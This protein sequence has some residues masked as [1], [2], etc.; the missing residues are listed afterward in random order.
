VVDREC[1]LIIMASGPFV[2]RLDQGAS[3]CPVLPIDADGLAGKI[4]VKGGPGLWAI[5]LTTRPW[6]RPFL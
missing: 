6:V 1:L 4:T 3:L 5:A 2:A